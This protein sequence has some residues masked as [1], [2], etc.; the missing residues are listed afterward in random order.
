[1]PKFGS[2][3]RASINGSFGVIYSLILACDFQFLML[4]LYGIYDMT[5]NFRDF[6]VSDFQIL[7]LNGS[8]VRDCKMSEIGRHII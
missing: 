8:P 3:S 5:S 6:A 4:F 7:K 2:Q 1:V